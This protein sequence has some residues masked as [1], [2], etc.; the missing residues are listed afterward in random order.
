MPANR[1][2]KEKLP[3]NEECYLKALENNN[4]TIEQ[5][6]NRLWPIYCSI[7]LLQFDSV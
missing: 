2:E 4:I 1:K 6:Q 5:T 7:I 3:T